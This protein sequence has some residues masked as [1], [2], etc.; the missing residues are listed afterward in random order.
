MSTD[1]KSRIEAAWAAAWN[2]GDTEA[3]DQLL[4]PGY[5]RHGRTA[6]TREDL[7]AGIAACRTALPDLRTVIDDCLVAD[8]RAATRWHSSG[9]HTGPLLDVP[10]TGRRVTVSGATFSR[11]ENGLI[12]EEWVTWDPRQMLQALGIIT[13]D[14][15]FEQN[16]RLEA[17]TA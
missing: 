14:S 10:A 13:L 2:H 12:T 11:V 3:L 1:L 17:T 7:K 9:T 4:A 8:G 16:S 15:A 5:V 6:Q